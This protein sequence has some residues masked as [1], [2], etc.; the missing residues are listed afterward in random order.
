MPRGFEHDWPPDAE[1]KELI[2]SLGMPEAAKR[3]G[4]SVT[5]LRSHAMRQGLPTK[6][7]SGGKVEAQPAA[8]E[9]SVEETLRQRVQELEAAAKRDRKNKVYDERI[10]QAVERAI[11]D[12]EPRY[13]PSPIPTSKHSK[14]SHEFVLLWSDLHAGE[15]V[16]REETGGLN[17]YDWATMLRRHDKLRESLF[18]YQDNRPYPVETLHIFALGDMLSGNIHDELMAT[19]EIPLAEA[20]VQLGLDG[21]EWIES[22]TERFPR[23]KVSGVVGNHPRSHKKPWAKQGFDN[24]DWSSLHIMATALRRNR[25][26]EFDIPKASQHRVTV[27]QNWHCLLLHG[28]GI[29]SSMPGVPWGGVMRR[30]NSLSNQYGTA[31]QPIHVYCLGHFHSANWVESNAGRIAM[32]GSV[33]GVDEYSIKQFGGGSRPQQMLLTFH[34]RNGATDCSIIDLDSRE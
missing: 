9:V 12:R 32:N 23:I 17:A 28:D 2:S 24:A 11:E 26:I 3:L 31:G 16:S 33:K 6:K 22:L 29:R 5:T 14:T 21:A 27:A 34:P 15:V 8:E 1:I 10:T 25:R 7:A 13:S 19:N 30:V 20:T 18:S 4:V